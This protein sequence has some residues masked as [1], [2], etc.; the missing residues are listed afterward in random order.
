MDWCDEHYVKF[1]TRETATSLAWTW[2]A[3]A[4][5]PQILKKVD[6]AGILDLGT[7][8]TLR[9]LALVARLPLEV[10]K[11]GLDVLIEDGTCELNG[12]RLVMPNFIQAQEARKT[13]AR[14]AQ[15]YREGRKA[16]A[17]AKLSDFLEEPVTPRHTA[18][19]GVTLLPSPS[20]AQPDPDP[21]PA[22][23]ERQGKKLSWHFELKAE[24]DVVRRH[25]L[26]DLGLDDEAEKGLEPGFIAASLKR[27]RDDCGGSVEL[28]MRLFDAYC[29]EAW[30]ASKSPPYPY[31]VFFSPETYRK[32]KAKL[33]AAA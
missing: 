21:S 27:V 26:E 19:H 9:N 8:Q 11:P 32:I 3:V 23:P 13:D 22:Q 6:K 20:S 12:G 17:R 2:Q 29:D 15:D 28:V 1:Y 31:R 24:L 4:L 30:P 33:E 14:R 18:S 5:F 25:R 10:V 7:Q 16:K